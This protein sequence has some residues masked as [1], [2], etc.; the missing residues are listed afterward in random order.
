MNSGVKAGVTVTSDFQVQTNRLHLAKS[1]Q[2]VTFT[3]QVIDASELN[4]IIVPYVNSTNPI[5]FL[6][7]NREGLDVPRNFFV[8][9]LTE[10]IPTM[11]GTN[12]TSTLSFIVQ[13]FFNGINILCTDG[14]NNDSATLL[15]SGE[16]CSLY[17]YV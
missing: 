4:W 3:C 15:L 10:L 5:R 12:M 14:F 17:M 16:L 2:S 8:G 13:D 7:S 6:P 9:N 11:L 1:T